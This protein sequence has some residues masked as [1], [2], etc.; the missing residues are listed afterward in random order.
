MAKI[1]FKRR[2]KIN[3]EI[4]TGPMADI[5]FLLVIF[6]MVTTV[7]VVYRGFHVNLPAAEHIDQLKSRRNVVS[8]WISPEGNMM[9]DEYTADLSSVAGIVHEKLQANPRIVVLVKSDKDTPYRMISGV[10]EE[11][12]KANALR[13]SFIAKKE[14]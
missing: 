1:R 10:I 8:I 2:S 12:K 5:S 14:K 13:V 6:F 7:F 9:V 3:Q 11:L 4:P